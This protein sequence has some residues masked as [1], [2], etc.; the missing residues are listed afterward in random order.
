MQQARKKALKYKT[1]SFIT[2]FF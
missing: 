2:F 1:T